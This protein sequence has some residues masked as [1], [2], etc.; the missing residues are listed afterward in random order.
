LLLGT[1]E[2]ILTVTISSELNVLMVGLVLIIF[3]VAAPQGLVGLARGLWQ[4][5]VQRQT[6]QRQTVRR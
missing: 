6:V 4:R 3:V 1:S 5:K 2:Q